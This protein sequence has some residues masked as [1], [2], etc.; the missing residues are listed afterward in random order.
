MDHDRHYQEDDYGSVAAFLL[1]HDHSQFPNQGSWLYWSGMQ[2]HPSIQA[3]LKRG[4]NEDL[5]WL[6]YVCGE[7][8]H[9]ALWHMHMQSTQPPRTMQGTLVL[10]HRQAAD[11][12]AVCSMDMNYIN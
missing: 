6:A 10:F 11:T 12:C 5:S 9:L 7:A 1:P 8:L 3:P 4:V 2:A